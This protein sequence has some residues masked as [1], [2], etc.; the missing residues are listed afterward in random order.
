MIDTGDI[1]IK[2]TILAGSAKQLAEIKET[3]GTDNAKILSNLNTELKAQVH[4]LLCLS[5]AS[6][7]ICLIQ[8][9]INNHKN[10]GSERGNWH[11]IW[12]CKQ[13]RKQ[14]HV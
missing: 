12:G 14:P 13:T 10:P 5:H 8:T 2:T 9:I 6:L 1:T 3:I 7:C 11:H 4:V